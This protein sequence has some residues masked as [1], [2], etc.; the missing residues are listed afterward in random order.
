MTDTTTPTPALARADRIRILV[1]CGVIIFVL[2]TISP[3]SGFQVVPL[4]FILKN[5]LHLTAS[6][7]AIFSLWASIP[8]FCSFAFGLA[9]DFWNPFRLGDR[10]FFM[11]FGGGA[12]LSYAVFAFLPATL[13]M[14]L[15]QATLTAFCFLF[16]WSAWNGLGSVIGQQFAMSGQISALWN[17]LGTVTIFAALYLGGI[18]SEHLETQSPTD[19]IRTVFLIGAAIMAVV[20]LVGVWR[21]GAVYDHLDRSREEKR[22]FL[23]DVRRLVTHKAIYPALA[24]WMIW[25]FSPGGSTVLQYHMSDALH[26]TD[27]Q[28]GAYAAVFSIAFVPTLLL[29][30]FLSPRYPLSRLMWWGLIMAVPQMLPVLLAHTPNQVV[31]TAIP[32]GLLGGLFNGVVLDLLIRSCPKGLEGTLMMLAWS[33]YTVATG[34]GNLFGTVIYDHYGFTACIVITTAVY[35]LMLPLAALIPKSLIATPDGAPVT[36]EGPL[37]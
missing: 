4:A 13:P 9:R 21:P 15:A 29:F 3:A 31:L 25:N 16:A 34:V 35:A 8:G 11:L 2:N 12:A 24:I 33:L 17:F 36:A 5:K 19:A 20:A 6:Q 23:A 18:L 32:M 7:L 30:G 22:D 37:S 27:S 1:Y 10:G 26:G 28:Y 14:L